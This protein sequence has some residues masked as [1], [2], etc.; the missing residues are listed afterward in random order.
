MGTLTSRENEGLLNTLV[1]PHSLFRAVV[2][3]MLKKCEEKKRDDEALK[4]C[5]PRKVHPATDVAQSRVSHTAPHPMPVF[6]IHKVSKAQ[7]ATLAPGGLKNL[8][9]RKQSP[10]TRPQSAAPPSPEDLGHSETV[11]EADGP[12][13]LFCGGNTTQ[14][15][16][17]P[18]LGVISELDP[19]LG[20]PP[21]SKGLCSLLTSS[22]SVEE[23]RLGQGITM[24]A[25]SAQKWFTIDASLIGWGATH[26]RRSID[27]KMGAGI[28]STHRNCLALMFMM[29]VFI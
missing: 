1:I 16:S 6:R 21:Q 19:T 17:Y 18:V 9:A 27:G 8:W 5:L 10:R 26:D 20:W 23:P 11:P 2:T 7:A 12:D 25:I 28:G 13:D 22:L 14:S 4:L 3:T 24:D 15:P 29:L